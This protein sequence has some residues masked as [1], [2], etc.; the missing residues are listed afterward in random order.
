MNVLFVH[1]RA[2]SR[3][4]TLSGPHYGVRLTYRFMFQHVAQL[5]THHGIVR[6]RYEAETTAEKH[7][8]AAF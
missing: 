3:S 1:H 7:I 5:A 6:K 2:V 8:L 4:E